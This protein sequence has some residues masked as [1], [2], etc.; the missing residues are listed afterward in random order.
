M[1]VAARR[2][3]SLIT[4]TRSGVRKPWS[5]LLRGV[6][7]VSSVKRGSAQEAEHALGIMVTAKPEADSLEI[8]L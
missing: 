1:T 4:V 8:Q 2:E 7:G 6:S 3:G 5:L